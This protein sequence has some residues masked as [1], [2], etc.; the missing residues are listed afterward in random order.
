MLNFFWQLLA[1]RLARPAITTWIILTEFKRKHT[2][3]TT[4]KTAI[5]SYKNQ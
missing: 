5:S 2:D 3:Q 4:L 1:E